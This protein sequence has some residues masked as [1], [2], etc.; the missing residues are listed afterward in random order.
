MTIRIPESQKYP[1]TLHLWWLAAAYSLALVLHPFLIGCGCS[2]AGPEHTC[3]IVQYYASIGS[4]L[5]ILLLPAGLWLFRKRQGILHV[6]EGY[7]GA[8]TACSVLAL[9]DI[10]GRSLTGE[11]VF[12]YRWEGPTRLLLFPVHGLKGLGLP[13]WGWLAVVL[14]W[15]AGLW[16]FSVLLERKYHPRPEKRRITFDTVYKWAFVLL[17]VLHLLFTAEALDLLIVSRSRMPEELH[18]AVTGMWLAV[19]VGGLR[20]FRGSGWMKGL[21]GLCLLWSIG[22]LGGGLGFCLDNGWFLTPLLL[23]GCT[24]PMLLPVE[25]FWNLLSYGPPGEVVCGMALVLNLALMMPAWI[26][27]TKDF[28]KKPNPERSTL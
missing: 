22:L 10:A 9:A 2:M 4:V 27:Y 18:I 17:G 14:G 8:V 7:I 26:L 28:P 16:V 12:P 5:W 6:F 23:I 1:L 3:G 11:A 24:S 20:H 19:L 15:S 25:L 13:E 21:A